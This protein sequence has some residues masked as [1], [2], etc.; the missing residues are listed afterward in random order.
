MTLVDASSWIEFLRGRTSAAGQRVKALLAR[1]DAAWCDM[2]LVELWNGAQG[3]IEK[4][5]LEELEEEL[6]LYPVNEQVWASAKMLA[7][8][9]REKGITASTAAIIVAACAAN[10]KLPLEHC[11]GHF[12]KILP[13][14]AKL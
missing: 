8:R 13:V 11:D 3:H 12:D 5:A 14:A 2:T 6:R 7:R 1:G 4:N 10:Y 9:C